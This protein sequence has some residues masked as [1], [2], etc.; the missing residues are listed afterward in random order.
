MRSF[1][2]TLLAIVLTLAMAVSY[3]NALPTPIAGSAEGVALVARDA[4]AAITTKVCKPPLPPKEGPN[5]S[6]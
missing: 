3:G 2:T 6:T 1:S 5:M 4:S